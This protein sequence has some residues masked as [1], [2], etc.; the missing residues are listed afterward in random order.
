MQLDLIYIFIFILVHEESK[1]H[2]FD[3]LYMQVDW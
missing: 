2:G 1:A 3:I